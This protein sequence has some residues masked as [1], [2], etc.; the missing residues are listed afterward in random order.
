MNMMFSSSESVPDDLRSSAMS[1]WGK[2]NLMLLVHRRNSDL[3]KTMQRREIWLERLF[4]GRPRRLSACAVILGLVTVPLASR[5]ESH[6]LLDPTQS[7]VH[8]ALTGSHDV[9]G[10]FHITSGDIAFDRSSG[11]MSGAVVVSAASGDS[12]NDSRD[13]KMKKDQLKISDYPNVTFAPSAFTGELAESGTSQ[14]QVKGTFTLLGQPHEITVPMTVEISGNHCAATGSFDIPYV[15]WG[16]KDPSIFMLKV[17]KD[18]KIDLHLSG[19][20]NSG[21]EPGR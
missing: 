4:P 21:S 6:F 3:L 8:F 10:T 7:A 17:G 16:V 5:A 12:G 20:I 15:Q 13:K 14:I 2:D 9:A 19:Q 11:K 18:V 1:D